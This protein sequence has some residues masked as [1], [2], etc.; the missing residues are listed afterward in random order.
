[1]C[2]APHLQRRLQPSQA[3]FGGLEAL[4]GS[5]RVQIAEAIEDEHC[6]VPKGEFGASHTALISSNYSVI[7]TPAS[8]HNFITKCAPDFEAFLSSTPLDCT[9][10]D[11]KHRCLEY[12]S[13]LVPMSEGSSTY[14]LDAGQKWETKE[15]MGVRA[16]ADMADMLGGALGSIHRCFASMGWSTEGLID[17]HGRSTGLFE[18]LKFTE[19]ELLV[20]RLYTGFIS[21]TFT[22]TNSSQNIDTLHSRTH[23]D[24]RHRHH[25]RHRDNDII[26]GRGRGTR[27]ILHRHMHKSRHDRHT[28]S[29]PRADQE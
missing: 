11:D 17:A 3:F 20:L 4:V 10:L 2:H 12:K 22:H 26:I 28:A 6:G 16:K 24:T 1:M 15:S 18:K 5:P 14:G 29:R 9:R 23:H 21:T 25:H 19:S 8:E 27:M 7:F 13:F